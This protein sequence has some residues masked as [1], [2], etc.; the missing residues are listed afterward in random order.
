M[1]IAAPLTAKAD[2][3][4]NSLFTKGNDQ[5]AK[6]KYQDAVKTYQ[7]IL[8]KGYQS[9][10]VYFNMGNAYY[11]LGEIP[12]AVLYYEKA[13][14]LAPGDEDIKFNI[15]LANAKTT[16]KIEATPGFFLT[17]WWN[18]F[19]LCCSVNSLGIITVLLIGAGFGV[20]TFYLFAQSVG[21]K[22]AS[23]YG[24]LA[25]IFL[26]LVTALMGASQVHYFA[27]HHQAVV[28]NNAV[29]VKSEP[30]AASKNLFVI[31]DGTKVDILE[32]NNGWMRI[33]LSNG[34]EG[35]MMATDVKPI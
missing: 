29:T 30:G 7:A 1:L 25:L 3:Q 28:F 16:D 9:A 31:H 19:I 21:L 18:A 12:S 32:D 33:R 24:A 13:H 4:V 15:Q 22:K 11:K 27:A 14:K 23:F 35:W 26:G 6:A 20:L 8:D 17:N 10:V 34:N 2:D 5:Y